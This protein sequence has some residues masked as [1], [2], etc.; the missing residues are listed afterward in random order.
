MFALELPSV[1]CACVQTWETMRHTQFLWS[2]YG[3]LDREIMIENDLMELWGTYSYCTY[4]QHTKHPK[5]VDQHGR[6]WGRNSGKP[7]WSNNSCKVGSLLFQ[8]SDAVHVT[9]LVPSYSTCLVLPLLAKGVSY[10][11]PN[12]VIPNIYWVFV[13]PRT[14]II[15]QGVSQPLCHCS[16]RGRSGPETPIPPS[17]STPSAQ[18]RAGRC[19]PESSLH[20]PRD[21]LTV[22]HEKT[23]KNHAKQA[24]HLS[25]LGFHRLNV[26]N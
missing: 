6:F 18:G 15:P 14:I 13:N 8:I 9:L 25:R 21:Q 17:G 16:S 10:E 12:K 11:S 22:D 2:F 3:N 23:K 26:Q 24:N 20:R 5:Y 7:I 1:A 4:L 19:C